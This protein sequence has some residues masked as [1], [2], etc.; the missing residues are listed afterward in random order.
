ME[1]GVVV[2]ILL[3]VI[4]ILAVSKFFGKTIK[5]VVH[6]ML[7]VIVVLIILTVIVYK[8]MTEIKQSFNTRNNTF[9]LYEN[10]QLY[11]AVTLKPLVS[12]NLNLESFLY[13]T[14]YEM[15]GMR[16][17][18]NKKNYQ[19]ILESQAHNYKVFIIKPII[20]NKPYKLDLGVELDQN[21]LLNIIM[22]NDSFKALAEKTNDTYGLSVG[23]VQRGLVDLYG[24]R[25]KLKG[26][27]LAGL[28]AN[29]FQS[30]QPGELVQGI[31]EKSM[32]VYP[33]SISFKV[34]KYMPW[35]D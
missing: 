19:A 1:L 26:Y 25:E 4:I 20:L 29:Y 24:S 18:M 17:S 13:F 5:L 28:L 8:D 16:E 27:L 11:T 34:I 32:I 33:E 22:S 23:D 31:K 3:G 30:Q 35:M 6:I 21:D 9:L 7:F 15:D 12:T 14:K 10:N 2:L